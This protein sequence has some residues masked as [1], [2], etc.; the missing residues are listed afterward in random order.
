MARKV[1]AAPRAGTPGFRPPEVLL[2][3]PLQTTG[4]GIKIWTSVDMVFIVHE[5]LSGRSEWDL[6]IG[7]NELMLSFKIK[8]IS[9]VIL[10]IKLNIYS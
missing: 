1:Q 7:A 8:N 10:L 2:K 6:S 3:Y 4:R 9:S 5:I